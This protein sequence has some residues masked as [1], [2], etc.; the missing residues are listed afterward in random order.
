MAP[1]WPLIFLK[2]F[3]S[4]IDLKSDSINYFYYWVTQTSEVKSSENI[5]KIICKKLVCLIDVLK[6][7]TCFLRSEVL[8]Q[9]W[10]FRFGCNTFVTLHEAL[11]FGSDASNLLLWRGKGKLVWSLEA[12]LESQKDT[13]HNFWINVGNVH[14]HFT[15]P[16]LQREKPRFHRILCASNR[17][18]AFLQYPQTWRSRA[19]K[20]Y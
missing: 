5:N 6:A 11:S 10:S 17:H 8:F 15:A 1:V 7:N 13:S 19:V 14:L 2:T 16:C 12:R 18:G 9:I 3:D 4:E 20:K